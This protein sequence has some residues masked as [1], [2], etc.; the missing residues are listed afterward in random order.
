MYRNLKMLVYNNLITW[1][2]D[3]NILLELKYLKVENGKITHDAYGK[4]RQ[5]PLPLPPGRPQARY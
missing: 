5:T 3:E 4:D 1:P 2:D